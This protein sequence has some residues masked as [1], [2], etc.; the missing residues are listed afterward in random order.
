[1]AHPIPSSGKDYI[2]WLCGTARNS[3]VI[4]FAIIVARI[5]AAV[6][7]DEVFSLI[8]DVPAGLVSPGYPMEKLKGD[9]VGLVWSQGIVTAMLGFLESIAIG[10]AFA[11]KDGY[12]LDNTQEL[13][14]L[15]LG[16]LVN[17]FFRAYPITGSFSRTAVNN[18][19][20]VQTPLAGLITG[21]GNLDSSFDRSLAH[22]S[23]LYHPHPHTRRAMGFTW[24]PC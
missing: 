8:R 1:M 15:G 7:G 9:E 20:N 6:E 24:C 17:S 16:N 3:L 2:W 5:V 13:R 12:D 21:C 22:Y 14:A 19:S 23:A 11:Q 18:A 4:V 10:K